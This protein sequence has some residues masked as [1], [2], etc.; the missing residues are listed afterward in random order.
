MRV[1]AFQ[2]SIEEVQAE[3]QARAEALR[4][5]ALGTVLGKQY[6]AIEDAKDAGLHG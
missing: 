1:G 2:L 6:L 3:S 4:H 5:E